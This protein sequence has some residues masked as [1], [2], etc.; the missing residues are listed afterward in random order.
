AQRY[1]VRLQLAHRASGGPVLLDEV[2][3]IVSRRG[4]RHRDVPRQ[5]VVQGRDVRRA[6]DVRVAAKREDAA[7]GPPDVAEQQLDDRRRADD[8]HTGGVLGPADGVA[9][10]RRA[11]R[12]GVRAE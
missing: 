11:L 8:L 5:D 3:E 7:A 2:V 4:V 10:G 12:T 6:L 1:R 9:E